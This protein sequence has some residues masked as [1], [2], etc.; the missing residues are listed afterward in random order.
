MVFFVCLLFSLEPWPGLE[1]TT[2][3][4]LD[5]EMFLEKTAS[6]RG[7]VVHTD[8]PGTSNV[9]NIQDLSEHGPTILAGAVFVLSHYLSFLPM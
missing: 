4:K 3:A 6:E 9:R 5:R 2:G 8:K 1:P 7:H